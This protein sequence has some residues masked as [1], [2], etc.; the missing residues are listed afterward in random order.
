M[1][2]DELRF[3][4]RVAI[5]TG[6]GRGLGLAHATLLA[7]RGAN[8][9]INDLGSHGSGRGSSQ[10]RAEQA[11]AQIVASGGKAIAHFGDVSSEADTTALVALALEEFGRVDVVVNNAGIAQFQPFEDITKD[12]L[13]FFLRVHLVGSFLVTKA[14]WPH[15]VEQGYGRVVMTS[16]SGM[17]GAPNNAKYDAAKGGVFG[18][19]KTLS[20]TGRPHGILVNGIM[21]TADT[22][23]RADLFGDAP[24]AAAPAELPD[25]MDTLL[26]L[27]QSPELVAPAVA[28]LAHESCTDSGVLL[29]AG[30]GW[31]GEVLMSQ[32][33]GYA[34]PNLSPEAIRD[35]WSDIRDPAPYTPLTDGDVAVRAL[36]NEAARILSSP[37]RSCS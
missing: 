28:W 20:L 34:D 21:P 18:L 14:A 3:D 12:Q 26:A 22:P 7:A 1:T 24:E 27:D 15:M 31:L 6:A 9:V 17:L 30:S 36:V 25:Y 10:V 32:G 16:S 13:E 2:G 37:T 29:H 4:G 11:A 19:M 8:V 35:H 5:V 23:M 33:R